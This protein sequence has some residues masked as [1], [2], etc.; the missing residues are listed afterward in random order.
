VGHLFVAHGDL[1][2]LACDGL[3]VPCDSAGNVRRVW[4][5]VLPKGLPAS[6]DDPDWLVLD[7]QANSAGVI[8][9][10]GSNG[11]QVWAF[12]S[13]D[14]DVPATPDQVAERTWKAL[15]HVSG[16]V[17][18]RDGRSSPLIGIPLAG[19]GHG[20]LGM[21]RAKVIKKLLSHYRAAPLN[22]D[23]VLMLRD[24][25]DFAA[26]QKRRKNQD[27]PELSADLREHADRLGR[28]AAAGQLSL[29]L[30]SG[31]SRPVGLPDWWGLLD[32]LADDAGQKRPSRNQDP[33]K[34]ATPIV[35]ALGDGYHKAIR[36]RL[37]SRQHGVAHALLATLGSKR[38]VTT[39]FD[40]CME[41]ALEAPASKDFRV[42]ARQLAKGSSPWLL[43]LNGDIHQP[44]TLVLT[45][46]DLHR[47]PNQ[48][49]ALGGV[50]QSLL[51][52]SHLFFVGFSLTDRSFLHLAHA[53]SEVRATAEDKNLSKPGTALALTPD[54]CDRA[55]FTDLH[56]LSMDVQSPIKG[57]RLL[58]IFLDRVVWAA[59]TRGDLASEYLLDDRYMSGLTKRDAAL[60]DLLRE[61][62]ETA[63]TDAKLSAGWK[64]V[65]ACLRYL[66]LDEALL[67]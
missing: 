9:Q 43:K 60:R 46:D 17:T 33:Y 44:E 39:N 37:K 30:G 52:T 18:P 21:E 25:R 10:P 64:R 7:G 29:F 41:T 58:E 24:R 38:M 23:V 42:L 55:R 32:Q 14:F 31:V 11:R 59:A 27:W 3:L 28:L 16:I 53:V 40:R 2:K 22:A 48:R 62:L 5:K 15:K 4:K 13:V 26:V 50:V 51:L 35:A 19:V 47:Y 1:T 56:T 63:S 57:A 49:Q 36:R 67:K 65:E 34:A 54:E 66:G 6:T 20:G 45:D 8:G 61:L 12:A